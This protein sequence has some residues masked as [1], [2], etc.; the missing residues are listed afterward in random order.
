VNAGVSLFGVPPDNKWL[1]FSA[2]YALMA[3]DDEDRAQA[4]KCLRK[5]KMTRND[6][7]KLTW[8]MLAEGWLLL[9]DFRDAAEQKPYAAKGPSA[10]QL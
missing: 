3:E 2:Q 5:A 7:E 4:A 10:L 9:L 8:L 6:A 1:R